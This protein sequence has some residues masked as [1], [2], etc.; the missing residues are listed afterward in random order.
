MLLSV[1][2]KGSKKGKWA[3][4]I[5]QFH[6]AGLISHKELE[7]ITGRLS[8]SQTSIFG[9]F[10]RA[11]M[12]PLYRK[13]NAAFYQPALSPS[14]IRVLEWR[15]GMLLAAR[16]RVIYPMTSTPQRIIFTDEATS[17][18][19]AAIIIFYPSSCAVVPVAEACR[20]M[21]A[22]QGMCDL[23]IETNLIYGL[24]MLANV[25]TAADP[26]LD[27]DGQCVTFYIDDNNAISAL[28]KGGSGTV[29]ISV[30]SRIFW[31]ICGRSG[32]MP[33]L[34]RAP[35]PVN[36]ADIPARFGELPFRSKSTAKFSHRNEL[37]RMVAT[38]MGG[39]ASGYLDPD[40]LIGRFY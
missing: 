36:I 28:I 23:F 19:I 29:I 17:T 2:L 4:R 31:E 39:H 35:S 25:Q 12:Q 18:L 33:W 8:Y 10:G 14:D 30:L 24:E 22:G 3:E 37:S 16:P 27:L 9:R 15:R 13:S 21:T 11:L 26:D 6:E 38:A 32:I 1:D 20:V 5:S 7:S 40:V 34:E